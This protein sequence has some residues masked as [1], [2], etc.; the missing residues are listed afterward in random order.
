MPPV[1]KSLTTDNI[2]VKMETVPGIAEECDISED[3][4]AYTFK[5]RKGV[6]FYNGRT[7]D[8]DASS[9]TSSASSIRRS[10]TTSPERPW[11]S[12][13][14]CERGQATR[15][16]ASRRA[17]GHQSGRLRPIQVQELEALGKTELV[18]FENFFD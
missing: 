1:S 6:E 7:F 15:S 18:R 5:L 11:A 13:G 16:A 4:L 8:A 3:L 2:D 17:G 14:S 10:D 9:G 12:Q